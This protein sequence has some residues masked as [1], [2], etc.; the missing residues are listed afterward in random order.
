MR[1]DC[2]LIKAPSR[3]A[4]HINPDLAESRTHQVLLNMMDADFIN[5]KELAKAETK[6]QTTISTSNSILQTPYF[7]DWINEQLPNYIGHVENNITIYTTLDPKLQKYA[8]ASMSNLMD[9]DAQRM[10]A[11]QGAMIVMTP[12]GQIKAM[13]GGRDYQKSQYNRATKA[14]R[15]PGSL[16]KVFVYLS[17]VENGLNPN[18]IFI[19]EPIT[20]GKWTPENFERDYIGEVTAK[21]AFA[22]SINTVAVRLG[23]QVGWQHIV[24]T[25]KNLGITSPLQLNPSIALGSNEVTILEMVQAFAHFPN[26]G[27]QVEA[28]G[29]KKIVNH[30]KKV[31]YKHPEPQRPYLIEQNALYKM[32]E[33]MEAVVQQGTGTNANIGRPA[34]GKTGTSTDFRDAWFI[35]FT[36]QLVAGVWVGNDNNSP[37]AKTT[38]GSLPAR[39]WR[40][41]MQQAMA[42]K[43]ALDIPTSYSETHTETDGTQGSA[44]GKENNNPNFVNDIFNALG[45]H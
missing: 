26:G 9:K 23:A 14:L 45:I 42:G 19:D 15:Q 27:R 40:S 1:D 25:A 30:K 34:A 21:Q 31:I 20:I 7:A 22:K 10:K 39:I 37:M 6:A 38:G 12:D 4:P 36:P 2:W 41:F 17:A 13:I 35:G 3:Y 29:I 32:N 24:N 11:S 28:Y 44:E 16:F 43:P 18:D 5:Q 33:L 8:E